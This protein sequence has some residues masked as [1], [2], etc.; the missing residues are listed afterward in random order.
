LTST[1]NPPAPD[2]SP[3]SQL[4]LPGNGSNELPPATLAALKDKCKEDLYFFAKG[5][6]GYKDLDPDIH[7]PLC[8][9]LQ[10]QTKRRKRILLPRGWFKTTIASIAYP[11]WLAIR[12][13][14]HKTLIVQNT[15]TN[16]EAKL[17]SIKAHFESNDLFRLLFP[18]LLPDRN[19]KWMANS[20]QVKRTSVSP[21]GTF[22]AAGIQTQVTSRHY[23]T[24]IEDDTV[25]P[26]LNELGEDNLVPTKED[27]AQ[28]IGWHRLATP[29]LV[30]PTES[31]ILVIG[32]RWF[33]KD[34][35]S[36][37]K[38][39][40]RSYFSYERACREHNGVPDPTGEITYPKRFPQAVLEQLKIDM[41][42]YM[43]SCLYLNCPMSSENMTFKK[44]WIQKYFVEP[45]N[46]IVTTTVD[47]ANDPAKSTNKKKNTD[48]DY[49]IVMTC[50]KD[51]HD[52]TIYVLEYTRFKGSPGQLINT[53]FDH[54]K[55]WKP[56]QVGIEAI[57][58]QS[59]IDY[60]VRERMRA[61][62]VYFWVELLTHGNKAK[63]FRIRALQP[64]IYSGKLKFREHMHDLF[65]E[66]EA[67]PLGAHDDIIDC[68]A[69]QL[70][71]WA[72]TVSVKEKHD[73]ARDNPLS[74][75]NALDQIRDSKKQKEGILF[76]VLDPHSADVD[77][78]NY[79][80][81][82]KGSPNHAWS[83]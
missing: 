14:N 25:A 74:L 46:L 9:L 24:I 82:T 73:K 53:I 43:F 50:G 58:Y 51:L 26:D 30:H 21:E 28:A 23:D 32:T 60:W 42:P 39:N 80:Y 49:N 13:P 12:D 77:E 64:L 41:G 11:I 16:A 3:T 31:E 20:A 65:A 18:D 22:D 55:R 69:M 1:Q 61:E 45:T 52:G 36:W 4:A 6:L 48:F 78:L 2:S 8:R 75:D 54:V 38:D 29:L 15:S 57:A 62:G 70:K 44:D 27:I 68:L 59:S 66:L 10:D 37:I 19:C 76:D 17:K 5:V 79:L 56:V 63:E 34:L 67:F 35:L 71:L 33:E 40:D 72:N 7:L 47:P 83:W 81:A